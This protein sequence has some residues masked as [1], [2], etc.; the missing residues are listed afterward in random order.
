MT[1]I[2]TN[3]IAPV[4]E[5]LFTFSDMAMEKHEDGLQLM[6]FIEKGFYKLI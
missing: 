5:L 2:H 6:P 1:E 4:K 3:R